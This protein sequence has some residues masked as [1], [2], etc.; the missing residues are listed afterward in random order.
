MKKLLFLILILSFAVMGQNRDWG[1]KIRFGNRFFHTD[2]LNIRPP[3]VDSLYA[4]GA[5]DTLFSDALPI[6]G[7]GLEGIFGVA[8]WFDSTS[9]TSASM[10][11][12]V[13]FGVQFQDMFTNTGSVNKMTWEGGWHQI[14]SCKKDTLYRMEISASDSS[15]WNPAATHRQYRLREADADTVLHFIADFI[16]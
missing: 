15:W 14:W 13:R 3:Y 12:D 4:S 1:N 10:A 9:G 6:S 5:K 2:S 16:R 8:S 7:E 11:L